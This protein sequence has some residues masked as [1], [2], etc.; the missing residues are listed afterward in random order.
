MADSPKGAQMFLL[1]L[2]ES[3]ESI[4]IIHTIKKQKPT[5]NYVIIT[6]T[7]Q[8]YGVVNDPFENAPFFTAVDFICGNFRIL[9]LQAWNHHLL[10]VFARQGNINQLVW[11]YIWNVS[12][13]FQKVFRASA[14]NRAHSF[15][16][17]LRA[18]HEAFHMVQDLLTDSPVSQ[19]PCSD[20]SWDEGFQ[21]FPQ[22]ITSFRAPCAQ[23][24]GI[25]PRPTPPQ[26]H[27][28]RSIDH[29][30]KYQ[31]CKHHPT[32]PQRIPWSSINLLCIKF[33]WKLHP[34]SRKNKSA[35]VA[36]GAVGINK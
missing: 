22:A 23:V 5:C 26:P 19:I 14:P 30:C 35:G 13:F 28:L 29:V 8:G 15:T 10:S 32:P 20:P 6:L 4:W 7:S 21:H 34:M 27:E 18:P 33:K 31:E 9:G 11:C 12:C 1:S 3:D 17:L 24:S 2:D 25:R 36:N 16:P